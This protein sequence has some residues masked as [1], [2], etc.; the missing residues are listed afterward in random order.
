MKNI[1]NLF[2]KWA[3]LKNSNLSNK[4]KPYKCISKW[5]SIS[6][7]VTLKFLLFIN[8]KIGAKKYGNAMKSTPTKDLKK[9]IKKWTHGEFSE[10]LK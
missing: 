10:K 1:F 4:V 5:D 3:V 8:I 6:E 9:L 7:S 2:I